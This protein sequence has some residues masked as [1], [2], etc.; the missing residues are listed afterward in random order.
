MT[1]L[2]VRRTLVITVDG[3]LDAVN[4]AFLRLA[5]SVDLAP[6]DGVIRSRMA[7]DMDILD[8]EGHV[9][10]RE[11]LIEAVRRLMQK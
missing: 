10:P 6:S 3:P 4:A 1:E 11:A 5:P 2:R 7:F 9:V 8:D